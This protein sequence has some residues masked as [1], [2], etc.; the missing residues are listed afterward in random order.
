MTT[1]D[2]P[3]GPL[4]ENAAAAHLAAGT[5][6][7]TPTTSGKHPDD[8]DVARSLRKADNLLGTLEQALLFTVLAAV[9]LTGTAQA[10][11]NKFFHHSFPWSF[12]VIRDGVF[13]IAMI[14]AAFASHQER[15]LSMD[16]VSRRLR[17]RN[18]LFLRVGL[19]I[20]TILVVVLFFRGGWHLTARTM[21]EQSPGFIPEWLV[22]MMIPL[23]AGLIIV[24]VVNQI[25]IDMEYIVRGKLPP[26]RERSAH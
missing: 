11:S 5:D 23:G 10:I 20:A 4:E 21:D 19:G 2:S 22:A 15:Q 1:T 14:G 24:H 3:P 8:G 6:A 12:L 26:E 9:A 7:A 18:R 16:L 13:A 25:V 17:P